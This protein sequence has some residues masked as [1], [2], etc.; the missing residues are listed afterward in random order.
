MRAIIASG[1]VFLAR[2][3]DPRRGIATPVVIKRLHPKYLDNDEFIKRFRH[4]AEIAILV[5]SPH[6]AK[7]YEVGTAGD[8]LFIAMEF[9]RGFSIAHLL[10][11]LIDRNLNMAIPIAVE[12]M[13]GGLAGL[14]AIHSATDHEGRPLAVVHRDISPKNLMAGA[15]GLLHLIDLGLGK[16]NAQ[17][18]KTDVGT[19]MGSPGYMAPEQIRGEPVDGRTDVYAMG[20]VLFE[21]L[22][23]RRFVKREGIAEMLGNAL[24]QPFVPPSELRSDVPASLDRIVERATKL[25]PEDRFQSAEA[26]MS[27]L[28]AARPERVRPDRMIAFMDLVLGNE[29]L[30]QAQAIDALLAQPIPDGPH[31]PSQVTE[32]FALHPTVIEM[33]RPRRQESTITEVPTLP[34]GEPTI[35][36]PQTIARPPQPASIAPRPVGFR[37]LATVAAAIALGIVVGI[38]VVRSDEEPEA[39]L[40]DA[41]IIDVSPAPA[42]PNPP[43]VHARPTE[44]KND[45]APPTV[46]TPEH[47]KPSPRPLHRRAIAEHPNTPVNEAHTETD[48]QR[49]SAQAKTIQ[50]R[51]IALK[52]RVVSD[53]EKSRAVEKL[54][55]DLSLVHASKNAERASAQLS[56]LEVRLRALEAHP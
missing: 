32:V 55:Y 6:V 40:S 31:E 20:V 13:A 30:R 1:D 27:A 52:A 11:E 34:P 16:S 2:P 37:I 4:E 15:D 12:L 44:E 43:L 7:V 29:L 48:D 21:L 41:V 14:L 17:D 35:S 25:A 9:V 45:E 54:L 3:I 26:F 18:W 36:P 19:I 47:P 28:E 10:N 51:A 38:V 22:T 49:L 42:D 24:R 53:E 46:V 8:T 23:L 33:S 50:D 56:A 39:P 5:D